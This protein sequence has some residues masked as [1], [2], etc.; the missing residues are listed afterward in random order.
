MSGRVHLYGPPSGKV[1]ISFFKLPNV[2]FEINMLMGDKKKY[3]VSKISKV[4]EFII[5]VLKKL[6]WKNTVSPNRVS[7]F[8][9]FPGKKLQPKTTQVT[10]R[11]K[12]TRQSKSMPISGNVPLAANVTNFAYPDSNS[13]SVNPS[14]LLSHHN[15]YLSQ[16]SSNLFDDSKVT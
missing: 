8:L 14:P 1:S 3:D 4:S 7:I 10:S 9:P 2:E 11:S 6:L 16:I 15:S 12:Y 13:S 5:S